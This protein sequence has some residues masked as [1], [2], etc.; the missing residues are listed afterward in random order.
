MIEV[1]TFLLIKIL[2]NKII[3][4][5]IGVDQNVHKTPCLLHVIGN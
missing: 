3:N 2:I 4:S 1:S 5:M